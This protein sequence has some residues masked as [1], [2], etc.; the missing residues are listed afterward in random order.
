MSIPRFYQN[1]LLALGECA[2]DEAAAHHSVH[3]L[4]LKI[5]SEVIV[6][7]GN[8]DEFKGILSEVSKKAVTVTLQQS[9]SVHNESFLALHLVQ[10]IS[11]KDHMDL[12][13]QKAVELGVTQITPIVSDFS[14]IKQSLA[15]FK[16]K[17]DHWQ[18]IIISASQQAGRCIIARL[19]PIISFKEA[20]QTIEAEQRLFLSPRA[21]AK[22]EKLWTTPLK[23]VALFVG[24]EGGF[25]EREESLA[26]ANELRA[27]ALGSRILRTETAAIAILAILQYCLGD[28]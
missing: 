5:G 2:L 4:R 12:T 9:Y 1:K 11:R 14:N 22:S 26:S 25:S 18:K 7:N 17:Q 23:S 24:C 20:L 3:V 19:N 8:G 10:A 6:F 15:E 16:H 27:I 28:F 13:L 21:A